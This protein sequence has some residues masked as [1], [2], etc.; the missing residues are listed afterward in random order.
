MKYQFRLPNKNLVIDREAHEIYHE[1]N[2][3]PRQ[4]LDLLKT[5]SSN[6]RAL[7]GYCDYRQSWNDDDDYSYWTRRQSTEAI[8]LIEAALAK[9]GEGV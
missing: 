4:L 6:L 3:T 2:L 5:A 9:H 7:H 8:E 1:T